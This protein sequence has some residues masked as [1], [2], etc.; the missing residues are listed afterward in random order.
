M[1]PLHTPTTLHSPTLLSPPHI[2]HT[3]YSTSSVQRPYRRLS[4]H[5]QR[6]CAAPSSGCRWWQRGLRREI[7]STGQMI[8][9]LFP[10]S[11]FIAS[12]FTSLAATADTAA[13]ASF[14]SRHPRNMFRPHLHDIYIY[15]L[16]IQFP[17]G[18]RILK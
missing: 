7:L 18:K 2:P 12:T 5:P 17:T 11:I 14:V 9:A 1:T 8:T 13:T 4:E 15:S 6:K 10:I 16:L 3:Q